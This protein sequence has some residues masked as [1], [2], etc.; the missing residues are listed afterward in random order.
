MPTASILNIFRV[1]FRWINFVLCSEFVICFIIKFNF[2]LLF[3]NMSM[4]LF[5]HFVTKIMMITA[6]ANANIYGVTKL[7]R[8]MEII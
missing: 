3:L 7:V 2:S 8:N 6:R 4:I 1:R 5:F